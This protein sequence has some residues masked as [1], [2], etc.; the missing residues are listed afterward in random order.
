MQERCPLLD[1]STMTKCT[2][3]CI[4]IKLER[5]LINNMILLDESLN[6]ENTLMCNSIPMVKNREKE[7]KRKV[8]RSYLPSCQALHFFCELYLLP[9]CRNC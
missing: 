3:V 6:N 1:L 4:E 7:Q 9:F 2:V 5:Q 8:T